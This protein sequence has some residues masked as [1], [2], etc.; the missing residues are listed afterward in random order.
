MELPIASRPPRKRLE[1]RA[2]LA[3]AVAL[4]CLT[5]SLGPAAAHGVLA[6][7]PGL[8]DRS[9]ALASAD[10]DVDGKPDLLVANYVASDVSLFRESASGQYVERNPSPFVVLEG[11]VF[12]A[13]TATIGGNI[14][15][16]DLNGDQRPDAVIVDLLGRALSIRL[17]DPDLVLKATA[18]LLIGRSPQA[19]AVADF[20]GDKRLDLAVTSETDDLIYLLSGKGDGNF[21]FLRTVDARDST[22]KNDP[23]GVGAY[24]IAAADFNRDGKMDLAVTQRKKDSLAI[25]LGNGTFQSP[26]TLPVGRNPTHLQVVRLNDD[27]AAGPSDDFA[28]LAVLLEGGRHN[29][30]DTQETPLPGGAALL[31]GSGN[32]TFTV[33]S[34]LLTA[35]SDSPVQ[36]AAGKI[37]LGQAGFDDLALVNFQSSKVF[38]YAADG[39]G[40]L[41][42]LPV[43]LGGTCRGGTSD[44]A[45][46]SVDAQCPGGGACTINSSL[47]NP[48]GITLMDR[49]GNGIV[50][51]IAVSNFS[52]Y[53]ITFFD[54]GGATPFLENPASPLTAT[55]DPVALAAGSLDVRTAGDDLA[56]LSSSDPTLQTF[57]S[58]NDGF[59]FKWRATPLPAGSGPSSLALGDFN[60]DTILD[61]VV[62]LTDT[63]GSAGPGDAPA[64][65]ILR[66]S[67][68]S[69]LGSP[70]GLCT[71]GTEAGASCNAD[72][73]CP[74]G[75]CSYSPVYGACNAGTNV[76]KA[77][78]TD[79]DCPGGT[80]AFT[81]VIR[82][83]AGGADPGKTCA[84][85]ADCSGGTC[86]PWS[87]LS[88]AAT[89]LLL[90][91]LNPQDAD[92][93]GVSDAADNCPALYNPNQANTRGL[94]CSG[95][96]SPP[97]TSCTIDAECA[98]G[99]ACRI[100]DLRGDACDSITDDLDK[101]LIVD[102]A[103]D[104]PEVYNPVQG[105]TDSNGVGDAC[106]HAPDLVALEPGSN[107][108][109]IFVGRMDTGF[110]PPL[111]VPLGAQ[112]AG[113]AAGNFTAGDTIPDLAVTD[114]GNKTFQIFAGSGTGE[115]TPLPPPPGISLSNPG[116]LVVLE[117]NPNDLDLDGVPNS[118]D[119]CPTRYNPSPQTDADGDG[120]GDAC[121]QVEDPDG[122]LAVTRVEVRVDNCP[123][124]YNHDQAD[125]DGDRIGDSCDTVP[126]DDNDSD[127][128]P[129]N[130]DNC[131]TRYNPDQTNTRGL[132]CS[133]G[134]SHGAPCTLDAE[135]PGGGTCSIK[136][137]RG[138]ACDSTTDDPDQDLK[139]DNSDNCPDTYNPDQA[140]LDGDRIGNLCDAIPNNDNDLD[141]APDVTDNCPT[142]YNP[143]QRDSSGYG[144]G[145]ACDEET[146]DEPDTAG[147]RDG[148]LTAVRIRD[149]C[150]DTY[151]PE[152]EDLDF[153]GIGDACENVQDLAI[154]DDGTDSLEVFIQSPPGSWVG[155]SSIHLGAGKQP[156]GIVA[157]DLNRDG[158]RDLVV[159]N[160]GDSTLSVLMG[161][162]DGTFAY[163]TCAGGSAEGGACNSDAACPGS[164]CRPDPSFST[165]Y[166]PGPLLDLRSGF[167]QREIIQP[168]LPEVAGVCQPLNNPVI[169]ANIIPER[170]DMDG[171][172]RVD[173]RDLAI[174]AKSFGL[175]RGNWGYSLTADVNLDG[176]I[177]GVDLNYIAFQFGKAVP[178]P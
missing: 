90:L 72:A 170:A 62:A 29:P 22:Q 49:D 149:N 48:R 119:N 56:V 113:I 30:K 31:R 169:L 69:T 8:P 136:D 67:G 148:I 106:D 86:T 28:D 73:D 5:G 81:T 171:S 173:G 19:V 108:A 1:S 36:I 26:S 117:A 177:D 123:D 71:G 11:P 6:L 116:A 20:T 82:S 3:L 145:N 161:Q 13:T 172:N 55:R 64:L 47:R 141:G 137:L 57:S 15:T 124:T 39:N 38:L 154:V 142:R 160:T 89:S 152:Q 131:P 95:G 34:T 32:G 88:G 126:L 12:I 96:T 74:G 4:G 65:A 52:G 112:S 147:G 163:K 128:V 70:S 63:D 132:S 54:G 114:R 130:T 156:G 50:D 68:S 78:A 10:F 37:G 144:V 27:Q 155:F 159:S 77:C 44:G 101:D 176:K 166:L 102:N 41:S 84:S 115:F 51:R 79:A 174:W 150:P 125:A 16:L 61:A 105:D 143:D 59:F 135:C 98:G 178:P 103:D 94:S 146:D 53:S 60:R 127:G 14:E 83:C 157:V 58:L 153:D 151:N 35:D 120:V 110:F 139:M 122:D 42:A 129:D 93:D 17:S 40:G 33:A 97:G 168:S 121:S 76:L 165:V 162:G 104:C 23:E 158:Y 164:L 109:E 133:G 134:T 100:K 87:T 107:R 99:G 80:C 138:D 167:F 46:C 18:N 21:S 45:P 75:V 175:V 25:L 111:A 7:R 2:I 118:S 85:D 9:W 66:V 140:D 24:G 92:L 91:D 43:A